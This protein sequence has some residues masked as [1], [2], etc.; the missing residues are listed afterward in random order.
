MIVA[1]AGTVVL[2][3][4]GWLLRRVIPARGPLS[5]VVP[6][7]ILGGFIALVLRAFDVLPGSPEVWQDVAYHLFGIS[8]L[9]IGLTPLGDSKLR[10][11]AL[12]MGMGQWATFSLQAAAG[13]L[14]ALLIGSLDP[15]F[16]F[17]A[18]MGLN[19][20]PG[21]ALSIGR[22]WEADYG[23][24]D[25]A[26]IGATVASVG[27]VIAY[28]GGLFAVRGRTSKVGI[29][30]GRFYRV[31]RGTLATAG[32]A[33]AGY[34][35]LY[36]AV[37]HGLGA[38]APGLVDLVLGVLFFVALLVGM[39]VRR[40]LDAVGVSIDGTQTR[41]VTVV[42][43]DGLTVAILGSLTW[44]AVSGVIWP[45]IAVMAGAVAATLGVIAIAR[46]WL[47]AW[48]TERSLALFGTVTGTVASGLALL[49][50]TDP[51]LESPVAAELG[52]MVVVSAPAVV[53]GIALATA[54][55]SGAI[56][57]AV[58][59][60]AFAAAGVLSLGIL[61]LTMRRVEEPSPATSEE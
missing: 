9:A 18:P 48:R 50:L 37:L 20:G 7:A 1:L 39:A 3:S 35:V 61:A 24:T 2:L 26:S 25:A 22:L 32:A 23:F 51:D 13:G 10:K 4:V 44:A 34:V 55:A 6:A 59:V 8:F 49:A 31:N 15:G 30:V 19:E 52:A 47:D 38:V 16:G 60:A 42:A 11:G 43:I 5:A 12:W 53:A 58:G 28:V 36:E 54:A 46:R 41:Q 21:Q 14:I 45:L 56:S 33:V 29:V 40:V 57:E 27:F 17:L